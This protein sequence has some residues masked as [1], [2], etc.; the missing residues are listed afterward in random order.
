[1]YLSSKTKVRLS[2]YSFVRHWITEIA[3]FPRRNW[4]LPLVKAHFSGFY[5]AP[6]LLNA[7]SK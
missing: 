7:R 1:M 4:G 6:D 2:T 5:V 3:I